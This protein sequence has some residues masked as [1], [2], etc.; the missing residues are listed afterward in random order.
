M[1]MRVEEHFA[2]ARNGHPQLSA[3]AEHAIGGHQI[4]W[5]AKIVEVAD[6]SKKDKRSTG[7][8][9]KGQK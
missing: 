2:Q 6:K 7:N 5:K 4:E 9:K 8:P 3:V 1:L